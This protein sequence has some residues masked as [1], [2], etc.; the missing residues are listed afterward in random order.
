MSCVSWPK[1]GWLS[2]RQ[3]SVRWRDGGSSCRQKR[4]TILK[5]SETGLSF[6]LERRWPGATLATLQH[7]SDGSSATRLIGRRNRN[8]LGEQQF[9]PCQS[10]GS[11]HVA[12]IA[13]STRSSPT[14]SKCFGS[15]I[16]LRAILR[17]KSFWKIDLSPRAQLHRRVHRQADAP[18]RPPCR[19]LFAFFSSTTTRRF[20]SRSCLA[21]GRE[22]A[23]IIRS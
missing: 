19:Q 1:A 13:R 2:T 5:T 4:S 9:G 11:S 10:A 23:P 15:Y 21:V 12:S 7:C 16:W 14:G 17:S 18:T 6:T 22:G 20:S 3:G 8:P